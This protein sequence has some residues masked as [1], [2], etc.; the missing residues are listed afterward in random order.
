M[1]RF[2]NG[3][4]PAGDTDQISNLLAIN[5]AIVLTLIAVALRVPSA[6]EW[7]SAAAQAEFVGGVMPAAVSTQIAEPAK[8]IRTVQTD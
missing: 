2:Q 8:Q 4:K 3:R 1:Q 7:I 5:G 6:P